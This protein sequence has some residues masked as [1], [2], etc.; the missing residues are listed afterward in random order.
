[1]RIG[2]EKGLVEGVIKGRVEV[3][4]L[5]YWQWRVI[6]YNRINNQDRDSSF[7]GCQQMALWYH[8]RRGRGD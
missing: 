1:M 3:E 8:P 4:G 2:E 5:A 6:R 7:A